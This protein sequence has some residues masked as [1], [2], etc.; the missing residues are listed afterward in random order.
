MTA[1]LWHLSR[2]WC[3]Q[4][5]LWKSGRRKPAAIRKDGVKEKK[6]NKR[7]LENPETLAEIVW[8]SRC[9]PKWRPD[10]ER[11]VGSLDLQ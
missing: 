8:K 11:G 5:R 9:P 3:G 6:R 4:D 1:G 10:R 2:L 7:G